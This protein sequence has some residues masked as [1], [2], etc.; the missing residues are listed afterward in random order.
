MNRLITAIGNFCNLHPLSEKYLLCPSLRTGQIWLDRTAISGQPVVNV[1]LKT[2]KNLAFEFAD[3]HIRNNDL[4]PLNQY[5][6]LI[7]VNKILDNLEK[8]ESS[9]FSGVRASINLATSLLDAI[10]TLRLAGLTGDEI[11]HG[12]FENELKGLSIQYIFKEYVNALQAAKFVDYPQALVFASRLI[13][14]KFSGFKDRFVLIPESMDFVKLEQDILDAIPAESVTILNTDSPSDRI[15]EGAKRDSD[16]LVHFLHPSEAP[17]AL[18]DGSSNVFRA[19]GPANEMRQVLRK[20]MGSDGDDPEP[21]SVCFDEV[22]ILHTDYET[23]VPIIYE[24]VHSLTMSINPDSDML[25]V[26]FAEGIPV[27]YSRPARALNSWLRWALDD[28]PQNLLIEMI[29]DGLLRPDP[30]DNP[31]TSSS[32]AQ[33]LRKISIISG[34]ERTA[35]I[36]GERLIELTTTTRNSS[37]SHDEADSGVN[38]ANKKRLHEA[39]C[40]QELVSIVER[41]NSCSTMLGLSPAEQLSN[42]ITFLETCARSSDEMDNYAV[43][44]LTQNL[45]QLEQALESTPVMQGIDIVGWIMSLTERLKIM[46]AGPRPGMIHVDNVYSGGHTGRSHTF[47]VGMDDV[48]FPGAGR[49]DPLLMDSEREKLSGNL[50]QTRFE[51]SK[52]IENFG[53]LL[54][55]LRG[56]ITL[57]YSCLDLKAERTNFPAAI[58]F[59]IYRIL[60]NQRESDQNAMLEWL[61]LPASFVPILKEN[62]L[63]PNEWMLSAFCSDL[64]GAR[65]DLIIA[66]K[67]G[68]AKGLQAR[69]ARLSE[70]FTEYDGK[71]GTPKPRHDPTNPS[72]PVMSSA[73]LETIGSCPLQYFFKYILKIRPLDSIDRDH[74]R[75]LDNLKLGSLLHETFYHFMTEMM[76]Q[77]RHP[78]TIRDKSRLFRLLDGQL[79]KLVISN[80]PSNRSS[81]RRQVIWLEKSALV[82]LVEEEIASREWVPIMLEASI[83]M[84]RIGDVGSL[85]HPDPVSFNF[86]ESISIRVSGKIDRVDKRLGDSAGIFRIIDYKTGSPKKYQESRNYTR[87]KIVQ[88]AV[89]QH[90]AENFLRNRVRP[91]SDSYDFVYFFPTLKAHGLRILKRSRE[92]RLGMS[93]L[94]TLCDIAASGVFLPTDDT[95]TCSYCDYR[96]ICGDPVLISSCSRSKLENP[97]NVELAPIRKMLSNV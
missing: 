69:S 84:T 76:T 33:T 52:R 44:I 57:S 93:I 95:R 22:E 29:S 2:I 20:I 14:D 85:E 50:P 60:S 42:S 26:T 34:L 49:H 71:I 11:A 86:G 18:E 88:H 23:Y 55:R 13:P 53:L 58:L 43:V 27:K 64:V 59:S 5:Q 89:Y 35:R 6:S 70:H 68:L 87:G 1:R 47:I 17:Q 72:G 83:G 30:S 74:S 91:N 38:S 94:R 37:I 82:F 92:C 28:H 97:V 96:M 40:V 32:L 63:T 46:G 39:R 81:M 41:L 75:W 15:Q 56:S 73:S 19:L 9:Y 3:V 66:M 12:H 48:R 51:P 36:L 67:P 62:A 77:G 10:N 54:A 78:N 24:T 16:L 45:R 4:K 79:D 8:Q 80:P 61:G 65:T 25:P 90:I 31:V 7:I 21:E